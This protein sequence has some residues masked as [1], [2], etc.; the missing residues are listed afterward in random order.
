MPSERNFPTPIENLVKEHSGLLR[1][2]SHEL[3]YRTAPY[4]ALALFAT[5]TAVSVY[6]LT[7][8]FH[9]LI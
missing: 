8:K 1:Q 3:I 4:V 9:N 7:N 6:Y 2:D 5:A